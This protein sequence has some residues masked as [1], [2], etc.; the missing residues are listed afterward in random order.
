MSKNNTRQMSVIAK[1]EM[2]GTVE[3]HQFTRLKLDLEHHKLLS[4]RDPR[5]QNSPQFHQQHTQHTR[6]D[7][8]TA[9]TTLFIFLF[10]ILQVCSA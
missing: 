7:C 8:S 4:H 5:I 6:F 1:S 10:K 3:K 2:R 9:V